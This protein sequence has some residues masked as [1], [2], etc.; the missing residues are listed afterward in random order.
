MLKDLD[1]IRY[2]K[3]NSFLI[4]HEWEDISSNKIQVVDKSYKTRCNFIT[5]ILKLDYDKEVYKY[6]NLK[7]GDKVFLSRYMVSAK[8]F[9]LGRKKIEYST[10]PMLQVLGVF[11]NEEETLDSLDILDGNILIE[12]INV[13]QENEV[14][15]PQQNSSECNIGRVVKCGKGGFVNIEENIRKEMLLKEGDIVLFWQ[16]VSAP[17]FIEGK[18]YTC[19]GDYSVVATFPS[20]YQINFANMKMFNSR[21]LLKEVDEVKINGVIIPK[22][23]LE[24]IEFSSRPLDRFKVV[25][26]NKNEYNLKKGDTIV[27]EPHRLKN[28]YFKGAQLFTVEDID[29]IEAIIYE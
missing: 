26:V 13:T 23:D 10:L 24:E 21:V 5:R 27:I 22:L 14:I 28:V 2:I 17:L 11:R 9:E 1:K 18:N 19:I 15:L 8:R 16:N 7:E 4:A 29:D 20:E 25:L 6:H 3:K 12:P